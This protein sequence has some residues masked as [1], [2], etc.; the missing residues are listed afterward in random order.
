MVQQERLNLDKT[1]SVIFTLKKTVIPSD[2]KNSVKFL[3]IHLNSTLTW[4]IHGEEVSNKISKNIFL[5]RNLKKHVS[6]DVFRTAYFSLCQSHL[7]YGLLLWGHSS[8][9]HRLFRLQRKAVR[10]VANIGYRDECRSC[11]ISMKILTLPCIY[12][13][14]CILHLKKNAH[15]YLF[16]GEIYRYD[17]R[18]HNLICPRKMRLS[19]SQNGIDYFCIRF[20]NKL[21]VAIRDLDLDVLK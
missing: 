4:D 11:F 13:L 5:L 1:V 16:H 2:F 14:T 9:R 19:K 7:M 10:I 20:F 21:P 6:I 17:T 8:C 18:Q 15:S 12:I 3:G